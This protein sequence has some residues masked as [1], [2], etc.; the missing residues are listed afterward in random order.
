MGLRMGKLIFFIVLAFC[1]G[2]A[3]FEDWVLGLGVFVV[4]WVINSIW[5]FTAQ[6]KG[7]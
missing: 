5:N 7:V 6:N 2:I 3:V 4:Y 1:L